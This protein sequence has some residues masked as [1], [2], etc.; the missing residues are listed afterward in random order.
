MHLSVLFRSVVMRF[1]QSVRDKGGQSR[2]VPCRHISL[3]PS[4]T[5]PEGNKHLGTK[6]RIESRERAH[7]H[8]DRS[9]W[10]PQSVEAKQMFGGAGDRCGHRR[11]LASEPRDSGRR[12]RVGTGN[13]P[14]QHLVAKEVSGP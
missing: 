2:I 3:R 12:F 10:L 1:V 6:V 13:T 8:E 4:F 5:S 7:L 14:W 11:G 9:V